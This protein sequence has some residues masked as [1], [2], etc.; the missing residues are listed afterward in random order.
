MGFQSQEYRAR[1]EECRRKSEQCSTEVEKKHWLDLAEEWL[2]M[3]ELCPMEPPKET[4]PH[5]ENGD[6]NLTFD[7]N[8][9]PAPVD[10][11]AFARRAGEIIA[12][13]ARALLRRLEKGK[14]PR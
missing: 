1:A 9:S 13:A 11:H 10:V 14:A 8:T 2:R 6:N 4:T 7:P 3:A 12:R 5:H